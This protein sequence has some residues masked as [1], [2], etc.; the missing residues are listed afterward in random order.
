MLFRRREHMPPLETLNLYFDDLQT[1]KEV[2][3]YLL[4]VSQE[5]LK[6][7]FKKL[8]L[9]W[10]GKKK[11][12]ST[13]S[14]SITSEMQKRVQDLEEA[15]NEQ[16][17]THHKGQA[18]RSR[19]EETTNRRRKRQ[20]VSEF[21]SSSHAREPRFRHG[22]LFSFIPRKTGAAVLYIDQL[23]TV[24]VP[25]AMIRLIFRPYLCCVGEWIV[26]AGE[27][28]SFITTKTL[29]ELLGTDNQTFLSA[30][31]ESPSSS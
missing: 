29:R 24:C 11:G 5:P 30:R 25:Y 15:Y 17:D 18:K 7:L 23:K 22:H 12:N 28:G 4:L 21:S 6:R 10:S 9:T 31:V 26:G 8:T 2:I 1:L 13:V 20:K 14:G 19:R 3:T 27:G 16:D